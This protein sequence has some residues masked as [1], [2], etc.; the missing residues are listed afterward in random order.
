MCSA[1]ATV[2][3]KTGCCSPTPVAGARIGKLQAA[4]AGMGVDC[5]TTIC[6]PFAPLIHTLV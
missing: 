3:H 6:Q 5:H 2:S 4:G 1:A